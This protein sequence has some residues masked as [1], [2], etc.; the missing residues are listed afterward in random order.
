MTLY[1]S[2]Q[3]LNISGSVF[4][5]YILYIVYACVCV[6][7]F[8]AVVVVLFKCMRTC[9]GVVCVCAHLFVCYSYIE[10]LLHGIHDECFMPSWC[11]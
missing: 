11:I 5:T 7:W 1:P 3:A 9:I 6:Y 8:V 10:A 4:K 2:I